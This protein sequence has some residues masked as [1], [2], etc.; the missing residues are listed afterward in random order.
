MKQLFLYTILLISSQGFAQNDS[1]DSLPVQQ[2]LQEI[3]IT[4]YR[5]GAEYMQ[6][7]T[8]QT[9]NINEK[10]LNKAACCNL[11]ES[12]ETTPSIDQNFS[13][14]L[15]GYR[16]IQMLGL[17]SK[18]LAISKNNMPFIRGFVVGVRPFLNTR[19]LG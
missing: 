17:E 15:L 1:L 2:N 19:L 13:D 10:E 6:S 12:F 4:G 16:Q 8:I 14:A 9:I 3:K 7:K 5:S 18:Y 11:S